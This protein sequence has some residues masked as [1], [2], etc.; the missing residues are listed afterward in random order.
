[1]DAL[2]GVFGVAR[3][4]CMR[5]AAADGFQCYRPRV[6]AECIETALADVSTNSLQQNSNIAISPAQDRLGATTKKTWLFASG[7]H[8]ACP[9]VLLW[10][11]RRSTKH[12]PYTASRRYNAIFRAFFFFCFAHNI[13]CRSDTSFC[14]SHLPSMPFGGKNDI[15]A[16][17]RQIC[18]YIS[19]AIGIDT[20][21]LAQNHANTSKYGSKITDEKNK[22]KISV[23]S[24]YFQILEVTQ[25]NTVNLFICPISLLAAFTTLFVWPLCQTCNQPCQP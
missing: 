6:Y 8:C 23:L 13:S 11:H 2:S 20:L 15:S 4:C 22:M 17:S 16:N 24:I 25:L 12:R 1:M 5:I 10:I 21:R 19:T 7:V 18:L 9:S 3:M 14:V